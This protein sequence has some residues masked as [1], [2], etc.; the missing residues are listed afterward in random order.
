MLHS[1]KVEDEAVRFMTVE[2]IRRKEGRLQ[3]VDVRSASEFAAGHI[4]GTV[5]V[6]MEQVE[7]R[8]AD[9]DLYEPVVLVCNSGTRAGIVRDL[10]AAKV[11]Q[12][13]V[14]EGGTD[15][16]VKVAWL[17]MGMMLEK[18]PWNRS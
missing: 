4:P 10:L 15:A 17:G 18:M 8:L 11:Q 2:Q 3:L 1:S 13:S 9:F 12:V 5:N 14:L 6:P 16:W 7:K